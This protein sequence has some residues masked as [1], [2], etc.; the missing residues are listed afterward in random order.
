VLRRRYED[1]EWRPRWSFGVSKRA[2][3]LKSSYRRLSRFLC[4]QDVCS[5]ISREL[6]VGALDSLRLSSAS[7]RSAYT[8]VLRRL[9]YILHPTGVG[10]T[11]FR[12]LHVVANP[13]DNG[14]RGELFEV[15]CSFLLSRPAIDASGLNSRQQDIFGLT[16]YRMLVLRSRYSRQ[17]FFLVCIIITL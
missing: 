2:Q 15:Q 6:V 8:S 12:A 14:V 7:R 17:H 16:Q 9:R 11:E 1:Y 13:G 3:W 4:V 10:C 5:D